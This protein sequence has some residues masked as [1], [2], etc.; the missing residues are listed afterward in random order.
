M[1]YICQHCGANLDD[2]DVFEYFLLEYKDYEE[3]TR[4]AKQYGWSKTNKVHFNR[5]LIIQTEYCSQTVICPEC[6][7]NDPFPNK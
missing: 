3:A 5:S 7:K 1:E 6:E 2:G 4:V